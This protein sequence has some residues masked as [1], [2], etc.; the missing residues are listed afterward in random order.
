MSATNPRPEVVTAERPGRN[1]PTEDRVFTT[2]NAVIVLDG[3]SQ[4]EASTRDGGWI[5]ERVGRRLQQLLTEHSDADLAD[6]LAETIQHV[7]DLHGL[8]PGASPSTTV[9]IVRWSGDDVDV[10]V[11]GDSPVVLLT[12]TGE[13][14]QVRDERLAQVALDQHMALHRAIRQRGGFGFHHAAEW[15]AL[16]GAQRRV[17]NSP[18][19]YWIVE[20]APEA[21]RH[22][23]RTTWPASDL[24][25][26]LTMTD[27]VSDGIDKYQTP[28]TWQ[29][30]I[31]LANQ[32]PARLVETVHEAEEDDMDGRRWP[33]NKRHDDKAVAL[34]RL[35]TAAHIAALTT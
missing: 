6:A 23:V 30:A 34:L 25:A 13:I 2:S 11:L 1:R 15:A 20:A 5:A 10:L 32:H 9:S 14:H 4:P 12:R 3:A 27:G 22:A 24:A 7:R 31:T 19:G 21:A 17:R 33:R 29:A 26:V 16:V 18:G 28:A 35:T 8:R